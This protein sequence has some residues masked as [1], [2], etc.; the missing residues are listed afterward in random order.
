LEIFDQTSLSFQ[1][2]SSHDEDILMSKTIE[3]IH[4]KTFER[5]LEKTVKKIQRTLKR[6]KRETSEKIVE[7]SFLIEF[8]SQEANCQISHVIRNFYRICQNGN[9]NFG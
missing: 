5:T 6:K 1:I 7:N 4:S 3:T 9:C 2:I 8:T